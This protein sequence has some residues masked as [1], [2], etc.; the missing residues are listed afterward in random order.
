M[1]KIMQRNLSKQ[2]GGK[3]SSRVTPSSSEEEVPRGRKAGEEKKEHQHHHTDG[4]MFSGVP[5]YIPPTVVGDGQLDV[6]GLGTATDNVVE[7]DDDHNDDYEDNNGKDDGN[8]KKKK[9]KKMRTKEIKDFLARLG[10]V[11]VLAIT[12][13]NTTIAVITN[14][15][16]EVYW[17]A[18]LYLAMLVLVQLPVIVGMVIVVVRDRIA[19]PLRQKIGV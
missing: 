10:T 6:K 5:D 13:M 8:G 9:K 11:L 1:K 18:G 19:R 7:D 17:A 16:R 12:T 15:Y 2:D 3:K 14:F 4:E